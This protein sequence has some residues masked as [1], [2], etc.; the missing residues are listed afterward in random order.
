MPCACLLPKEKYPDA[1]EWGPIL[2]K[3]LHA[4]AERAGKSPFPMYHKE[5]RLY[6]VR[7]FQALGKMIPCP[8]CKEHYDVYLK[9]HPVDKELIE[10]PYEAIGPFVQGWFWELHNW[11]NE[12]HEKPVFA[13]ENLTAAYGSVNIRQTIRLFDIP[14]KRAL[15]VGP[16]HQLFGYNEFIKYTIM[17]CSVYGI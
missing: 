8:S 12:S 15:R 7:F 10:M 16:G 2:W 9:E 11:V 14:M 3:V 5:E 6:L 4:V 17:L 13:Y 1:L